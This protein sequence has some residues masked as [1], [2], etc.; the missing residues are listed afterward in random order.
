MVGGI[1]SDEE[2]SED[3]ELS[4]KFKLLMEFNYKKLVKA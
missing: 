3:L 4:P 2:Q 1:D